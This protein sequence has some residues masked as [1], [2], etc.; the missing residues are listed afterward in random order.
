MDV[1]QDPDRVPGRLVVVAAIVVVVTIAVSV[2][3]VVLMTGELRGKLRSNP[4]GAAWEEH[5]PAQVG[6]VE[7]APFGDATDAEREAL[8]AREHLASFGWVDR[9]RGR[10]HVP[11]DVAMDLYLQQQGRAR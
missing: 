11:I 8:A 7:S 4:Q 10:V 2:V 1:R 3:A 5:I 6:H 9:T